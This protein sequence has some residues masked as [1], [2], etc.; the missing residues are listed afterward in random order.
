MNTFNKKRYE[1]MGF[2]DYVQSE[3]DKLDYLQDLREFEG[4]TDIEM[5]DICNNNCLKNIYK[6]Y[7]KK[8]HVHAVTFVI[9]SLLKIAYL[10]SFHKTMQNML[11]KHII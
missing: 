9:H 1:N 8:Y 4:I 5:Q 2:P 6:V 7:V 11:F 10:A 3:Q